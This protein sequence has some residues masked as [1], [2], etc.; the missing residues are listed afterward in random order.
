MYKPGKRVSLEKEGHIDDKISVGRIGTR[1][2][3]ETRSEKLRY[4][5]YSYSAQRREQARRRRAE[6]FSEIL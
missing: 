4:D 5:T 6:M 2:S 3:V 1:S